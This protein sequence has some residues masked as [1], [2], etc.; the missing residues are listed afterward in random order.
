MSSGQQQ[1]QQQWGFS[2]ASAAFG[3]ASWRLPNDAD[4]ADAAASANV[5]AVVPRARRR[6]NEIETEAGIIYAPTVRRIQ[7]ILSVVTGLP[8]LALVDGSSDR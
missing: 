2:N 8:C 4:D 1:Q 3:R 5:V 7:H 6:Q